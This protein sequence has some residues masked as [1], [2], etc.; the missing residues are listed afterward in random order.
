M[1]QSDPSLFCGPLNDGLPLLII[2]DRIYVC[3]FI[4]H[5]WYLMISPCE[6]V[7]QATHGVYFLRNGISNFFTLFCRSGLYLSFFEDLNIGHNGGIRYRLIAYLIIERRTV[8]FLLW[9][10]ITRTCFFLWFDRLSSVEANFRPYFL[11]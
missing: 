3:Y 9:R 11:L 6:V 1:I 2:G 5:F 8:D 10:F 7:S 4:Y